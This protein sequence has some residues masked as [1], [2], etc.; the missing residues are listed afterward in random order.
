MGAVRGQRMA[1]AKAEVRPMRC[2]PR[3]TV[4]VAESTF[5]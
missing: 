4:I 2:Q 3:E 1:G 5:L